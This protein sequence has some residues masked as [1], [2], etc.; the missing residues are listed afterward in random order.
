YNPQA[1]L[2]ILLEGGHPPG[3]FRAGHRTIVRPLIW[4]PKI[5]RPDN[6]PFLAVQLRWLF[7][8]SPPVSYL[9]AYSETIVHFY[10]RRLPPEQRH[11]C[12]GH[13]LGR[14]THNFSFYSQ[15]ARR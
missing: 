10:P 1:P 14:P 7:C 6:W 12:Y 11:F 13:E 3:F 2:V 8:S 4:S 5:Y 9:E 15:K